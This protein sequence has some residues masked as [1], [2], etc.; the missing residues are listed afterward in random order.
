MLTDCNAQEGGSMDF[1]K[2]ED[3]QKDEFAAAAKQLER[4]TLDQFETLLGSP[5]DEYH[6]LS[7]YNPDYD[8][9]EFV[10]TIAADYGIIATELAHWRAEVDGFA[11]QGTYTWSLL[12]DERHPVWL[13]ASEYRVG[14]S[15]SLPPMSTRLIQ[16]LWEALMVG[17]SGE[18][19]GPGELPALDTTERQEKHVQQQLGDLWTEPDTVEW[20][21]R[22][23]TE[24]SDDTVFID[25]KYQ[26]YLDE[27]RDAQLPAYLECHRC[28]T[29]VEDPEAADKPG[30]NT[31]IP[32]EQGRR[33]VC[34]DHA[35]D[36]DPRVTDVEYHRDYTGTFGEREWFEPTEVDLPG[37]GPPVSDFAV[38]DRFVCKECK[39]ENSPQPV[40]PVVEGQVAHCCPECESLVLAR[41][42][43]EPLGEEHHSGAEEDEDEDRLSEGFNPFYNPSL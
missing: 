26:E 21:G 4:V 2:S 39:T 19:P 38:E 23:A 32:M 7:G 42:R 30:N 12:D 10:L 34:Q 35:Y 43:E 5:F 28:K 22:M 18:Y 37:D 3:T 13:A 16:Y 8:H 36:L 14:Y 1:E 17:E 20:S 11:E 6:Q 27:L 24:L 29:Q 9:L 33:V 41:I 15:G 31:R 25:V 40:G